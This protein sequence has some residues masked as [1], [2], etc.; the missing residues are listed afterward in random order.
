MQYRT[1]VFYYALA[2]VGLLA[3]WYFNLQFFREGGSIAPTSFLGSAFANPLTTAITVDVYWSALVFSIWA[4]ASRHQRGAP[5]PW[6]YI[7]LCFGV[8]L[9]FAFPLYLGRRHHLLACA[10]APGSAHDGTG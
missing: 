6:L 10:S 1:A 7:V 4:I 9:A 3:T 5:K 8:A 2:A